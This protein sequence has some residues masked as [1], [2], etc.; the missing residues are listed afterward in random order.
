MNV[1]IV[2]IVAILSGVSLT[3]LIF[4]KIV[5][6]IQFL[7]ERKSS[8][9]KSELPKE[10]FI[11]LEQRQHMMEKRLNNLETIIVDNELEMPKPTKSIGK[12]DTS[13]ETGRLKNHLRSE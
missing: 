12:S 4:Y 1:D 7:I 3:G 8:G 10:Q 5:N 13:E 2:A 6:F 11:E 9:S